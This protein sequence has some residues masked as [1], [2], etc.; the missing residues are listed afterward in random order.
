MES[1]AGGGAGER[2]V[3]GVGAPQRDQ[4][5]PRQPDPALRPPRLQQTGAGLLLPRARSVHQRVLRN[6]VVNDNDDNDDDQF[7]RVLRNRVVSPVRGHFVQKAQ[8]IREF[9]AL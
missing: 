2:R 8:L 4:P 5:Q 6:R 9:P 3:P 7:I 1:P